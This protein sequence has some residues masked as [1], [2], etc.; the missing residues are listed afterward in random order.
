MSYGARGEKNKISQEG[1]YF[2]TFKPVSP[3]LE[4]FSEGN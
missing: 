2:P 4:I 3:Y 1:E